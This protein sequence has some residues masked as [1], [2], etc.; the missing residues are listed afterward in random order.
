MKPLSR[1]LVMVNLI[2]LLAYM[3]YSVREKET[4]LAEGELLLFQLA[5][6]D[7]RSLIQGD[8]MQLRYAVAENVYRD[9]VDRAGF[10][11]V[12]K[13]AEGVA[14]KQR[15]QASETPLE[16]GE[17]LVRYRIPTWQMNIGAESFFFEEGT[18]EVYEAAKYGGLRIDGA[19]NSLL[20]GLYD[21]NR[22]LINP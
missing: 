22:Q 4:I 16:N 17:F 18:A 2:I 1:V 14:Q 21:E 6:V 11:V 19:G 9:S 7:P 15:L 10:L 5:P 20:V 3:L 13:D 12:T 8:Y